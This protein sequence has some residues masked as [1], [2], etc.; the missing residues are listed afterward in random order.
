MK[1][2]YTWRTVENRSPQLII[3]TP[4]TDSHQKSDNLKNLT[5][6]TI[7]LNFLSQNIHG[8]SMP[9]ICIGITFTEFVPEDGEEFITDSRY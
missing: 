6:S 2:P 5:R 8:T 4:P 3:P 9:A 1:M 7:K